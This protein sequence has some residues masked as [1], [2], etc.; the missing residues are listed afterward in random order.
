VTAA[1]A[2]KILFLQ[3]AALD[4][5]TY[6]GKNKLESCVDKKLKC[7]IEI[8]HL[9]AD[10]IL[11]HHVYSNLVMLAKSAALNKSVWDMNVHYLEL[12]DFFHK[13]QAN[14]ETAMDLEFQV[15]KSE[16]RL[17]GCNNIG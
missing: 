10:A 9:T 6:S 14:P 7:S 3:E 17:Y 8:A 4:F 13:L 12:S 1:N 2:A 16:P 5:L 11:F 15:F